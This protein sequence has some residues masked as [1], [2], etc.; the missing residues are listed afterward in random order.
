MPSIM[1]TGIRR[2]DKVLRAA[3]EDL[4]FVHRVDA[5]FFADQESRA[6]PNSKSTQCERGRNTASVG[7]TAGSN[8][9]LGLNC[10]DNLRNQR[11]IT[12]RP[13]VSARLITLRDNDV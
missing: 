2:T 10:I 13:C 6:A 12:D 8:H 9:G 1:A 4:F 3:R 5:A 7:N 11:K